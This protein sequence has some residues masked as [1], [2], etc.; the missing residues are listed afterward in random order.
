MKFGNKYKNTIPIT[1]NNTEIP[2]ICMNL[3]LDFL[4]I[5]NPI[6]KKVNKSETLDSITV[7]IV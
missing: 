1:L 2:Q 4:T 3:F 6:A 7:G 5:I